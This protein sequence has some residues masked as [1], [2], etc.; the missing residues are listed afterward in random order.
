MQIALGELDKQFD[1]LSGN[2]IRAPSTGARFCT[3]HENSSLP[4][5]KNTKGR[6]QSCLAREKRD[7]IC[8]TDSSRHCL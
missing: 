3:F 2:N 8:L 7:I 4:M 6:H 1:V 5:C